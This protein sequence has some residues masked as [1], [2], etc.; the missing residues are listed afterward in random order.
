MIPIHKGN[1]RL[2]TF[3]KNV[4]AYEKIDCSGSA[5]IRYYASEEYRTV[6]TVDSNLEEFVEVFTKNNTLTIRSKRGYSCIFTKFLVEVYC[7]VISDVS[8][9]G[10]GSFTGVDVITTP[11]FETSISG[12]GKIYG[13]IDCSMFSAKIS[14]SGKVEIV[15]AT[16]EANIVISGS[17]KF[18]GNDFFITNAVVRISGSGDANMWIKDHLKATISGSGRI[19]YRGNPEIDSSISGSGRIHRM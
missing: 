17:G 10:S 3:E 4:S 7:P 18:N 19:N 2:T 14:G 16:Q 5:E 15:G 1:G 12:S 9:S 13:D 11:S 8:L 6:V